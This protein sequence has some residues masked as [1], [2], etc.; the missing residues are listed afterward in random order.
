[1]NKK[2]SEL[3]I[4]W[5]K[6]LQAEIQFLKKYGSTKYL[7]SNGRQISNVN[8]FNYYFETNQSIRIPNG[9]NIK[10]QWGSMNVNGR[11]L[12][13]ENKNVIVSLEKNIGEIISEVFLI[14][15]PWELLEQLIE[16]LEEIKKSKKKRGRIKRL[17]NP[18]EP[19]KHPTNDIKSNVHE[20]ILRSQFN[21]VTFVWGPPGTGKTYTLA[22][23]AANK[24]NNGKRILV[25]A[26]SNQAVD[27]LMGE[28]SSFLQKK[29]RFKEGD[30]LRYSSHMNQ[31]EMA[32]ITTFHL[33]QA[34]HPNLAKEKE[35]LTEKRH[36]INKDL[37]WSFSKRDSE[38]LL[39]LEGKLAS[40]LEKIRQKEIQF[41]KEAKI[42]GATL[43]KVASDPTL[44][45]D[46]FDLVIVDEASMAY[47]PQM[48]FSASLGKRLIVCGD[49]K[50]L[51][52]IAAGRHPLINEWLKEDIFHQSGVARSV[53][54]GELHPHLL[55]LS[56]Q[57]R[58]HPD[59]SAFTNKF[60]YHS[61]VNDHHSVRKSREEM[62]ART[63]FSGKAAIL[64]SVS[65]TGEHCMNERSSNSRINLWQLLISFQLIYE[66]FLAGSRSIG[67]ITPYRAQAK[68]MEMLLADFLQK[69]LG[70]ADIIAAT[71]HRFQGSE[72]DVMIFDTVDSYPYERPGMLLI[73]HDSERLINVAITRTRGKFIQVSDTDYIQNKVGKGKTLRKLVDHQLEHDQIIYPKDIG[74]WILHQHPFLSWIHARKLDKV[75]EDI[76]QAKKSIV[77]SFPKMGQLNIDWLNAL[78]SRNKGV[79]LTIIS[80]GKIAGL[81]ID[82]LFTEIFSFPFV[83]I[84]QRILWLGLP[85]EGANRVQPP[86]VAARLE[87]EMIGQFLV[88]QF[89][90]N[91]EKI[92]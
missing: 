33:L 55:L 19:A 4:E 18:S 52:P 43:A 90:N 15:D 31:I 39:E 5:Q 44:F 46:E 63:P 75:L 25:L 28:I 45:E 1:M 2:I 3:I 49:F 80:K 53:H 22:R 73:G 58:M 67:F 32:P 79:E 35:Q 88:S 38:S 47:T 78:N 72:R 69:E 40:L 91:P 83:L 48:A 81:K 62:V 8:S 70:E 23:V 24:Y 71:V 60:I 76:R 65:Y 9:T 29:G 77:L 6:A 85:L 74:K 27:V 89:S 26:H 11:N 56:E 17:M 36:L 34:F 84:D 16:R 61:L 41:V 7:L 54:E 21:P 51:P 20:L 37:S 66:S 57:R 42:V 59:I 68:L 64:L 12:S 30:V 92:Y 82:N 87:S 50:Q 86:Y 10:I 14:H 13:T